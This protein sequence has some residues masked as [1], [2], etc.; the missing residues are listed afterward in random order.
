MTF[1]ISERAQIDVSVHE[2]ARADAVRR[3]AQLALPERD[4]SRALLCLVC[5]ESELD[6]CGV[7]PDV[8]LEKDRLL[9]QVGLDAQ[10][11]GGA[12]SRVSADIHPTIHPFGLL[13]CLRT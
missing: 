1:S 7:G 5:L 8:S 9:E 2:L 11:R 10:L 13:A 12:L 6:L 3:E 4:L